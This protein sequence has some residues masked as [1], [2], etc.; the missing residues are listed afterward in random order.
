MKPR[1]KTIDACAERRTHR[2]QVTQEPGDGRV[3]MTTAQAVTYLSL[4]SR[5]AIQRLIVEH[6][7][8]YH[9]LGSRLRFYRPELDAYL[10]ASGSAEPAAPALRQVR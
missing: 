4:G 9:R 6:A 8:P 2:G 5:Q 1:L 10:L 7:L 3:W